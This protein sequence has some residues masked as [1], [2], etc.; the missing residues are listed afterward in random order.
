MGP[1][2]KKFENHCPSEI[3]N[4][5]RISQAKSAFSKR[6]SLVFFEGY[7]F[8]SEKELGKNSKFGALPCAELSRGRLDKEKDRF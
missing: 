1:G 3:L 4:T 2:V 7:Q 8:K 6:K 5:R